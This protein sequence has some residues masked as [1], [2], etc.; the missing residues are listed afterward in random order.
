MSLTWEQLESWRTDWDAVERVGQK[1]R[2]ASADEGVQVHCGALRQLGAQEQ[3]PCTCTGSLNN[4][5]ACV[6]HS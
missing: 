4:S 5:A 6:P 2:P 3:L 1:A